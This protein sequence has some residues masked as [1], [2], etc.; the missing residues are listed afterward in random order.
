MIDRFY[1]GWLLPK[2]IQKTYCRNGKR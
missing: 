2:C 1:S